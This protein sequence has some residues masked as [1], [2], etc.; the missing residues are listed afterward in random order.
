MDPPP[1]NDQRLANRISVLQDFFGFLPRGSLSI[2]GN[3]TLENNEFGDTLSL[4]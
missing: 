3:K 4:G 2:S 1:L